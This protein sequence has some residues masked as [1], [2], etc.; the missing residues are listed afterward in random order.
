M[1]Q[2][3]LL[4]YYYFPNDYTLILE[5]RMRLLTNEACLKAYPEYFAIKPAS[6]NNVRT[7]EV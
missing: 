6:C 2:N 7:G 1:R 4:T 5:Y 3:P